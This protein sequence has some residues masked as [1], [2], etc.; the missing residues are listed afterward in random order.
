MQLQAGLAH[1]F[2]SVIEPSIVPNRHLVLDAQLAKH[3]TAT[4][5]VVLIPHHR[6]QIRC[7]GLAALNLYMKLFS[8]C[9]RRIGIQA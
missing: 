2:V 1:F 5:T 8:K 3:G 7:F 4:T 9:Y 6:V